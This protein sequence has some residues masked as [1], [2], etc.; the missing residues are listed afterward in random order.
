MNQIDKSYYLHLYK[1]ILQKKTPLGWMK[2]KN[3]Y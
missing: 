1:Y 3:I 2:S